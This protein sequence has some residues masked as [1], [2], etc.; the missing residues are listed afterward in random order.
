MTGET[1]FSDLQPPTPPR[2]GLLRQ[3][4]PLV[5]KP[6]RPEHSPTLSPPVFTEPEAGP[7]SGAKPDLGVAAR[8]KWSSARRCPG[9]G[10]G[11]LCSVRTPTKGPAAGGPHRRCDP[12]ELS[13][14]SC[15]GPLAGR[16]GPF[17]RRSWDVGLWVPSCVCVCV[18]GA[19]LQTR[20]RREVTLVGGGERARG[21]VPGGAGGRGAE[22]LMHGARLNQLDGKFTRSFSLLGVGGARFLIGGNRYHQSE[23]YRVLFLSPTPR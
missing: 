1:R 14:G 11:A 18:Q 4:R 22:V 19:C 3:A 6:R 8:P 16:P 12:A 13:R 21:C 9:S 23:K 10:L 2:K 20:L 15:R 17:A 7:G 5:W